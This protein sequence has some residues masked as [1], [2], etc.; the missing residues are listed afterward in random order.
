MGRGSRTV[1]EIKA[2]R[3]QVLKL[4]LAGLSQAETARRL[5]VHKSSVCRDLNLLEGELRF[6]IAAGYG[7]AV[8]EQLAYVRNT[9]RATWAV[10][11]ASGD[12]A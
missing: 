6:G 9:L 5:G 12:A 8:A 11:R 4:H 10:W 3:Q 1:A 2:K 7:T